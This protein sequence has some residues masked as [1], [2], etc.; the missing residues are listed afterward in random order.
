MQE[1][2]LQEPVKHS[3]QAGGARGKDNKCVVARRTAWGSTWE[4]LLVGLTSKFVH[5]RFIVAEA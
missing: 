2:S 4:I 1:I 5:L 3:S